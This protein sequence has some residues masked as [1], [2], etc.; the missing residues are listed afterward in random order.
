MPWDTDAA[1]S[2]FGFRMGHFQMADLAGLDVGWSKGVKTDDAIRD[3][4]CEL[5][6]R[7][8]KTKAGYYDYDASR[9][10]VPSEVTAR[11]IQRYHWS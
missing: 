5:D 6:R 7:G 4:L 10:P 11:L 8:Q 2:A 1:I 9:K 3:A